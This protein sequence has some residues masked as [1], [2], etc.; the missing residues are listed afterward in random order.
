VALRSIKAVQ[1]SRRSVQVSPR[2]GLFFDNART[3]AYELPRSQLCHTRSCP[4]Q[5][6]GWA[7]GG[8]RNLGLHFR[9]SRWSYQC[10]R[11]YQEKPCGGRAGRR[12]AGSARQDAEPRRPAQGVRTTTTMIKLSL[13][14]PTAA[15]GT[16]TPW[17]TK[18]ST[19][20]C[21]RHS[22]VL[23]QCA[24]NGTTLIARRHVGRVRT[25]T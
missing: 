5:A 6:E 24:K 23:A 15:P 25:R 18:S 7:N 1:W 3:N 13:C 2:L 14:M 19:R 20:C 4:S 9:R 11:G 12:G 16:S 10:R 21:S 17:T 8:S 22:S